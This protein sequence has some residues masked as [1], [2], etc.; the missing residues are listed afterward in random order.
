MTRPKNRMTEYL[1]K[2]RLVVTFPVDRRTVW[3][4]FVGKSIYILAEVR[5][6]ERGCIWLN[7]FPW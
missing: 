2:D 6:R 1:L 7:P 3:R 4:P 5:N